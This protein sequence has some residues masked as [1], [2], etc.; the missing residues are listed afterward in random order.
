M[1]L[2]SREDLTPKK[3]IQSVRMTIGTVM[4]VAGIGIFGLQCYSWLRSGEWMSVS[5]IDLWPN[6][7]SFRQDWRGLYKMFNAIP[8][9]LVLFVLGIWI[10]SKSHD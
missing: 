8:S 4:I 2:L 5:L 9:A 3:A 7:E 6:S 1:K 10:A